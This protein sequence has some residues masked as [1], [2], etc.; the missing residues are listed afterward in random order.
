[1]T[2][3]NTNTSALGCF[4]HRRGC[5]ICSRVESSPVTCHDGVCL[6]RRSRVQPLHSGWNHWTTWPSS[7]L[8][9]PT[10][11]WVSVDVRRVHPPGLKAV[12]TVT[13]H[14]ILPEYGMKTTGEIRGSQSISP[15]VR[16]GRIDDKT[17]TLRTVTEG[18]NKKK[19]SGG[20]QR[21]RGVYFRLWMTP[22]TT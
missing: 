8:W 13:G 22:L 3:T 12:A 9:E 15:V 7:S 17:N 18:G 10:R 20:R 6:M 11:K 21:D 5:I 16:A 2:N 19:K 14:M 1:M 4:L